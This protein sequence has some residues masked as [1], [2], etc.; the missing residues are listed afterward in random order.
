MFKIAKIAAVSLIVSSSAAFAAAPGP[1][2]QLLAAGCCAI[3]ACCGLGL[4]CCA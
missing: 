1:V 3:G 2:G 4:G